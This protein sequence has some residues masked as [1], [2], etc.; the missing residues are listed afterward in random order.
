MSRIV[1]V[2]SLS[3][4]AMAASMVSATTVASF[5]EWFPDSVYG[6]WPNGE[7]AMNPTSFGVKATGFGGG[8]ANIIPNVDA[9]GASVIQLSASVNAGVAGFLVAL[10]DT[11]GHEWNYAW[12]GNIPGGGVGGSNDY[13]FTKPISSFNFSTGAAGQ[14]DVANIDYIH[15]QVDPGF[16]P[17]LQYDVTYN[18]LSLVPGTQNLTWNNTGGT[19]D[20]ATW[21]VGV[22]QNWNNGT[23]PASFANG[24]NVSFTNANNGHSNVTIN[25]LVSPGSTTVDSSSAYAFNGTGGIGGAGGL[26]VSGTGSLTLNTANSYAGATTVNAGA[27]L[28]VNGSI[29]ATALAANGTVNFGANAST[30]ILARNLA[31]ITLASGGKV[32]VAAPSAAANRTVLVAGALTFGGTTASPEGVL[33]LRAN[34]MIVKGSTAAGIRSLLHAGVAG[35]AGITSSAAGASA[36][37]NMALGYALIS[38]AGTF[39]GLAVA[40]G[41]VVIKYTLVGD[42][43]L[44]GSVNFDDL[45][46]LAQ[47]YGQTNTTWSEGDFTYDAATN[48]DDLLGLAQ[49]YGRSALTEEQLSLVE[50]SFAS[51]FAL[52]LSLVPEPTSLSLLCAGVLVTRRRKM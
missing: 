26:T 31:S 34:D 2:V 49:N 27:T 46:T 24:D 20:G 44:N 35:T 47:K 23:G 5:D 8:Y 39:D 30:G 15:I 38:A 19:G 11:T 13:V 28:N 51:D 6:S 14:L 36:S 21:D 50:T 12:Y 29:P 7:L 42:A 37:G 25:T 22:S 43:D 32:A 45:L 16:N 1:A 52:A 10:G 17:T 18:D 3:A 33:D 9:T 48:F 40:G 4:L 41:D